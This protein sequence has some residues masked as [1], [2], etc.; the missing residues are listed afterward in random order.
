MQA[1]ATTTMSFAVDET[2]SETYALTGR[3]MR[4]ESKERL[5]P[6]LFGP[7]H[8]SSSETSVRGLMDLFDAVPAFGEYVASLLSRWAELLPE[9]LSYSAE[10]TDLSVD[11]HTTTSEQLRKEIVNLFRAASD[12]NFED[13]MESDFVDDLLML[14]RRYGDTAVCEISHLVVAEEVSQDAA[15]EALRWLGDMEHASTLHYRRWLLEKALLEC[16]SVIVRDGANVGLAFMNDPVSIPSLEK[17]IEEAT[18]PLL[19]ETMVQTLAQLKETE[20]CLTS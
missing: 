19:R 9:V 14:V 15:S 7:L 4:A 6:D 13:G 17:A 1:D 3:E 8:K 10:L 18:L 20:G 5:Y 2:T 16:T 12:E 11:F